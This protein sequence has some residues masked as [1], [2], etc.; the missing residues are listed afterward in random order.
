MEIA[1]DNLLLRIRKTAYESC[2]AQVKTIEQRIVSAKRDIAHNIEKEVY[3]IESTNLLA[4]AWSMN[5]GERAE[6]LKAFGMN[7]EIL[8][9]DGEDDASEMDSEAV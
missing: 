9:E 1:E 3:Q 2:E 4:A 5:A 6:V 8:D 7:P